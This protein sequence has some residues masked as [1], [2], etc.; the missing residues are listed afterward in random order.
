MNTEEL[1]EKFNQFIAEWEVLKNQ[2]VEMEMMQLLDFYRKFTPYA[3]SEFLP[4]F[5]QS[6]GYVEILEDG[7][8]GGFHWWRPNSKGTWSKD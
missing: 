1:V 2:A 5:E 3:K 7:K 8:R 6:G 4:T